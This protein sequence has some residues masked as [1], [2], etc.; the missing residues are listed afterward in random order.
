M[1]EIFELLLT[2]EALFGLIAFILGVIGAK[3]GVEFVSDIKELFDLLSDYVGEESEGGRALTDDEKQVVK[4]KLYGIA[5]KV[6][7]KYKDGIIAKI[8]KGLA[9][10]KFWGQ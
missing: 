7:M 1:N 10:I 6:W 5:Y 2:W 9:K 8:G 4:D 3:V